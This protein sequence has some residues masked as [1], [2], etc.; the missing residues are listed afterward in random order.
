LA[1]NAVAIGACA[2]AGALVQATTLLIAGTVVGTN[3]ATRAACVV[4]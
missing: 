2:P 3:K 1:A 4:I